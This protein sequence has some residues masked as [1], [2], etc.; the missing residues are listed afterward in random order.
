MNA[1]KNTLE[2]AKPNHR[3][4]FDESDEVIQEVLK[5]KEKAYKEFLSNP[6]T[7]NENK[8]KKARKEC[9]KKVEHKR[10]MV[11]Q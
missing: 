7:Q 11:E 9:Q 4:W 10:S 5:E 2:K 3:D 1:A 6:N 8:Y